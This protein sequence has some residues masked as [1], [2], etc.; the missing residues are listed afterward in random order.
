MS[1]ANAQRTTETDQ[2]AE[3][4]SLLHEDGDVIEIRAFNSKGYAT[5]RYFTDVVE[6]AEHATKEARQ[7]RNVYQTLNVL[8]ANLAYR[9]G[10]GTKDKEVERRRWLMVDA[11][12]IRPA[13][14]SADDAEREEARAVAREIVAY[15][16]DRGW[17]DAHVF[18][19]GNGLHL[20]YPID[21][22]NDDETREL[23]K[24]GHL[25]K[26][27]EAGG[28]GGPVT[29]FDAAPPDDD[30]RKIWERSSKIRVE[31]E[32]KLAEAKKA[33]ADSERALHESK[34]LAEASA[35][36]K[37]RAGKLANIA[38]KAEEL[39]RAKLAEADELENRL[40]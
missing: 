17:P 6:A 34:E 8:P 30:N 35:A 16:R 24:Y 21:R 23:L 18:D 13:G 26:E 29:A 10:D 12:P 33:K 15:S 36:A 1:G 14:I 11:D 5:N 39:G 9:E 19:S 38:K 25:L 28:F 7:G 22:P 40:R 4:L 27:A 20:L 37:E 31:G 32:A 3:G 2:I